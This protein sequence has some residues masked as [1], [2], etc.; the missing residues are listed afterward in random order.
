MSVVTK[1]ASDKIFFWSFLLSLSFILL[2]AIYTLFSYSKLP[3]VIPLYNQ[4]P[5][6]EA[7]IGAKIEI[8]IPGSVAFFIFLINLF[9]SSYLYKKMPLISRIFCITSLLT[10]FFALIIVVR[11]I[12][13]I[14]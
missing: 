1:I 12:R 10:N 2:G 4:F 6:G 8:F 11:L 14:I 7:R 3:P 5:W 13:L 9:L